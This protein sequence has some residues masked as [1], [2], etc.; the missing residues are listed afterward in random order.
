MPEP[1]DE[2]VGGPVLDAIK[3]KLADYIK[4]LDINQIIALITSLIVKKQEGVF[5][6]PDSELSSLIAEIEQLSAEDQQLLLTLLQ[7]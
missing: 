4:S 3:Q 6:G 7:S 5:S 2:V 1:Q